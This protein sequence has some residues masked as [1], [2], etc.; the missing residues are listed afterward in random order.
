MQKPNLAALCAEIWIARAAAALLVHSQ[1]PRKNFPYEMQEDL[2]C[3]SHERL[4]DTA[5]DI[6]MPVQQH[7]HPETA[8]ATNS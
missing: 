3:I 1:I 5:D 7:Q 8:L 6:Y 4:D 2:P